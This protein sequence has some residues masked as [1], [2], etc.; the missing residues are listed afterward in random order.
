MTTRIHRLFNLQWR[1]HAMQSAL[2]SLA[3]E[4]HRLVEM[5]A[6]QGTQGDSKD[7]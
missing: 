5:E 1:L 3:Q 2:E 6:A 7:S 4:I